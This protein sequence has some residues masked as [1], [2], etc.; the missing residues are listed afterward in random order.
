MAQPQTDGFLDR[1]DAGQQL[2]QALSSLRGQHP[3]ILAIPRGGV[4]IGRIVA[5]RLDGE[6]DVVLVRKIGAP[7]NPEY[8]IGAI[9]ETG[10]VLRSG[11]ADFFDVDD[12]YI[13]R[14]AA[15]QLATIRAR[16]QS[17]SLGHAAIDPAGRIAVVVD[18]GL[19]TGATMRAALLAVRARKPARLVCA[20]PVASPRGLQSV[21]DVVDD[22]V[23]LSAPD[24][25]RAVG[26]FYAN[27]P[28]VDDSEVIRLL[29]RSPS[30]SPAPVLSEDVRIPVD[31]LLLDGHLQVP[32]GAHGLV[33]FTHGSGSNRRS[34]R[35]RLVADAMHAKGL[36]TLLFDLLVEDEASDL[37]ARFDIPR[38]T[39]RLD[40]AIRWAA[41]HS[42][43]QSLPIGL[44]GASTGAAAALV[45]AARYPMAIKAVVS[46]GGRPDL[47][48]HGALAQVQAP[49]LL[50]VGGAD[51][52]VIALNRSAL[53]VLPCHAELVLVP[54]ATH[55]FEEEGA[56]ERVAALA[57]S[58]FVQWMPD[59]SRDV[60]AGVP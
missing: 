17:Y 13:K 47:A 33:I 27:F 15:E 52:E 39:A 51:H 23:C 53:L 44:F 21:A 43:T 25:F 9:D 38:L 41:H 19:A 6:F 20:V 56:I 2:A 59:Q 57:T 14:E 60:T 28:A 12:D 45:L 50:I 7:G 34:P 11:H 24:H 48:G 54:N 58:W 1:T 4:P 16:R 49:T 42:R 30:E 29:V 22:L 5:D 32:Q 3:L 55:L 46:R 26:Q 8:A 40:A 37:S 10:A 31:G 18:D 36:A 35:N